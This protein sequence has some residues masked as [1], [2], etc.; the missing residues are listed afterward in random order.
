MTSSKAIGMPGLSR[1]S[2]RKQTHQ[3]GVYLGENAAVYVARAHQGVCQDLP[4]GVHRLRTG[5]P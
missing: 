1:A 2:K 3:Q 4:E 5:S